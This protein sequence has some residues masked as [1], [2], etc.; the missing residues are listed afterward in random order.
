VSRAPEQFF[1]VQHDALSLEQDV[2][3][4]V[5]EPPSLGGQRSQPDSKAC[6]VATP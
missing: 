2:Q 1:V 4:S 3:A 5:A 6:V